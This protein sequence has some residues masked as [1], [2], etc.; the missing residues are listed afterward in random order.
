MM[1]GWLANKPAERRQEG[2]M[3]DFMLRLDRTLARRR[4]LVLG[5]WVAALAVAVPFAAR[6][7]EHLT[8]GGFG[9]PGSQS[10]QVASIVGQQFGEAGRAKLA[11]GVVAAPGAPGGPGRGSPGPG[12]A[13]PRPA[14]GRAPAPP[15]GKRTTRTPA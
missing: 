4:W 11:G 10:A 6:Q 9:V 2:A 8:G 3:Q 12:G 1:P 15:P 14:P 5:A 7:S 13:A